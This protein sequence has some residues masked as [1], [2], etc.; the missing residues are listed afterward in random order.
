MHE[1]FSPGFSSCLASISPF[2]K[3]TQPRSPQLCFRV[4]CEVVCILTR[5]L[6]Q[7][8]MSDTELADKICIEVTKVCKGVD[9]EAETAKMSTGGQT[10]GLLVCCALAF[11]SARVHHNG[12]G[13][14]A[15]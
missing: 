5:C 2:A 10:V 9:L 3:L 1:A 15:R 7:G 6:E 4:R 8:K 14:G 13:S 11:A 12:G